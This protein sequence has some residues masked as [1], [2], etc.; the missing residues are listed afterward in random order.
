[1]T[2][3][4]GQHVNSEVG[5]ANQIDFNLIADFFS[6]SGLD[7]KRKSRLTAL[8]SGDGKLLAFSPSQL[9]PLNHL[10]TRDAKH[11]EHINR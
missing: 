2:K 8:F 7:K 3:S 9:K 6:F 11:I 10:Q 5:I 4:P 1:M